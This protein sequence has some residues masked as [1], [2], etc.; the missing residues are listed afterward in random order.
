MKIGALAELVSESLKEATRK[1]TSITHLP[2]RPGETKHFSYDLGK[3]E[4]GLGYKPGWS[5]ERGV[6]QV[7]EYRLRQVGAEG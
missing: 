6:K 5:V 3:I 7:I 2:P 4:K 1:T